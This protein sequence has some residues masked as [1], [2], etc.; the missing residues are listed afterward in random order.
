MDAE[1][2]EKNLINAIKT[3]KQSQIWINDQK[4]KLLPERAITINLILKLCSL[5]GFDSGITNGPLYFSGEYEKRIGHNRKFVYP[6]IILHGGQ[7]DINHQIFA[8][9]V[10]K[11]PSIKSPSK[12]H[13]LFYDFYKLVNYL[14]LEKFNEQTQLYENANYERVYMI[15]IDCEKD[16]IIKLFGA[17]TLSQKTEN[18]ENEKRGIRM[19]KKYLQ[20]EQKRNRFRFI[21]IS[22]EFNNY[23][24][25]LTLENLLKEI[26]NF[27]TLIET[28]D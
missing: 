3:S 12:H 10:K 9:E 17:F 6:D 28:I 2:A 22:K 5:I 23:L 8:C 24:D 18:L 26:P 21:L 15:L 14:Y 1:T 20:D 19:I 16:N 4:D 27:N 13:E 11:F 7:E 25:I